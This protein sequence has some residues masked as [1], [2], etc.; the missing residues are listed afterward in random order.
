MNPPD[1]PHCGRK[2]RCAEWE[3]E[4]DGGGAYRFD[5]DCGAMVVA[6]Y[7]PPLA[8]DLDNATEPT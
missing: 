4:P 2:M 5:C 6:R 7:Y 1:C 8:D 3:T